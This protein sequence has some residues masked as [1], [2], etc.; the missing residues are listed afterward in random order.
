M[1]QEYFLIFIAMDKKETDKKRFILSILFPLS[2]VALLWIV[3]V[4]EV[5]STSDFTF[6]GLYPL[7]GKG[8]LG[9]LTGPLIHGDWKHLINNSFPLIILGWG[10]FYFYKE[11]AYKV[12]I[13]IYL[14][15]Q[16]WLWFFYVRPAW[17]IGA[18]GLIYGFGAFLFVSGIIRKNRHLMAISLLVAFLYGS[19][20][21]GILPIEEHISWEG[22]FMGLMAGLIL[23]FYYKDFGPPKPEQIVD[24]EEDDDEFDYWN[25]EYYQ[26]NDFYEKENDNTSKLP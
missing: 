8:L 20:V 25:E 11:I 9:I 1:T 22:H 2:F 6:L 19:M 26:D 14:L 23:A 17:H 5:T 7:H 16:I 18:S 12:F 21:W 13:L 10:I 24:D 3:K 15:S 4:I